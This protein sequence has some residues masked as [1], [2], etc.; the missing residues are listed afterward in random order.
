MAVDQ[1]FPAAKPEEFL[2]QFNHDQPMTPQQKTQL[3]AFDTNARSW[4][5]VA[6]F[7]REHLNALATAI[8]RVVETTHGMNE[9]QLQ[10]WAE[11]EY[12]KLEGAYGSEL[13][14][15][16]QLAVDVT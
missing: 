4:P 8:G 15:K 5:T 1:A 7:A 11:R 12:A 10:T 13:D 3:K 14:S 6:G 2:L 9:E 16:L